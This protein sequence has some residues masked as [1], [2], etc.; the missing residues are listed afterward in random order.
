MGLLSGSTC[1]S[2]SL[3]A[4]S[5]WKSEGGVLK[6]RISWKKGENKNLWI[7]KLRNRRLPSFCLFPY[8]LWE[9]T[10]RRLRQTVQKRSGC[11]GLCRSGAER[12]YP[13]PE[14]RGGGWEEL[15]H[16]RSQGW[17]PR[18]PTSRPRSSGCADAGGPRGAT[19]GSGSGGATS[20]K[21]RSSSCALLEQPWR[22]TPR[23]R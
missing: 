12:S 21:V 17:W 23:P 9:F 16:V 5:C 4:N 8:L 14:F 18:G 10:M 19:P 15:P 2:I 3:V 7:S 11:D 6:W 13:M 1:R 20:S 22:D